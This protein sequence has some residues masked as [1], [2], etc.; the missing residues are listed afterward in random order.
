MNYKRSRGIATERD[1]E[2]GRR[3]YASRS[4]A[5]EMR[6][7]IAEERYDHLRERQARAEEERTAR[8]EEMQARNAA[9]AAAAAAAR[10][11]AGTR[12]DT[13]ARY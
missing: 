4:A 7:R 3:E 10:A 12:A 8:L 5:A 13:R 9:A 11:R 2:S 6:A 1:V